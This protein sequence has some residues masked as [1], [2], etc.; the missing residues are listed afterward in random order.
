MQIYPQT[1]TDHE[2]GRNSTGCPA[3]VEKV[4]ITPYGDVIP[5]PFIHVSF[6][7]VKD[8]SLL[9]IV[10]KMRNVQYFN[11]Y[12]KICIA[13][14]DP[15]FQKNVLSRLDT[16]NCPLPVPHKKVFGVPTIDET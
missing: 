7:N 5:C 16:F 11:K 12:Q 4:Y 14:E 8:S 10:D 13:A 9:E 3:G 1:T 2:V 15:F 6:G